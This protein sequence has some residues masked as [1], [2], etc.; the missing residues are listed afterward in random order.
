MRQ[1]DY[2][3]YVADVAAVL[4]LRLRPTENTDCYDLLSGRKKVASSLSLYA[5]GRALADL[6][7]HAKGRRKIAL[8]DFQWERSGWRPPFVHSDLVC[9]CHQDKIAAKLRQGHVSDDTIL[10]EERKRLVDQ[11]RK[12]IEEVLQKALL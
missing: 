9:K 4:Q 7:D 11:L 8:C 5:A 1:L 2:E 3:R 6:V 12:E 10:R